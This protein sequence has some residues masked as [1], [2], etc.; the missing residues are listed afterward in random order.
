MNQ[1][2]LSGRRPAFVAL[3]DNA[4]GLIC[5]SDVVSAKPPSLSEVAA[6]HAGQHG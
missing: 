6:A 1:G 2:D 3:G 5:L 4:D